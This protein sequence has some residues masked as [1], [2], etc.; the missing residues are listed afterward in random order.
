MRSPALQV[1]LVFSISLHRSTVREDIFA[2][3]TNIA[4]WGSVLVFVFHFVFVIATLLVL[5]PLI[6]LIRQLT[7][8]YKGAAMT[9]SC[10]TML[11]CLWTPGCICICI[12]VFWMSLYFD[13]WSLYLHQLTA[14]YGRQAVPLG[15][16]KQSHHTA[17]CWNSTWI[18]DHC[19]ARL[20]TVQFA[21]YC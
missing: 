1:W 19:D 13:L 16:H 20:K 9:C 11:L 4:I 5:A 18:R 12:C 15:G 6:A 7:A 8:Q 2:Y 17:W 14:Q 3:E 21:T 10:N